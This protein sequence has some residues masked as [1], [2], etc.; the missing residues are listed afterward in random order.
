MKLIRRFYKRF[1]HK[2]E[3][4]RLFLSYGKN[5]SSLR[6]PQIGSFSQTA[7]LEYP[8]PLETAVITHGD[9]LAT[10]VRQGASF[11]IPPWSLQHAFSN[12]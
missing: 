9:A 11:V 1:I 8:R 10:R 5:I 3:S 2:K 7:V 4:G 12:G 6:L